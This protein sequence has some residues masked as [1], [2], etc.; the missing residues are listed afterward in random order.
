MPDPS[1][2]IIIHYVY[3]GNKLKEVSCS[4]CKAE[5]WLSSVV[6]VNVVIFVYFILKENLVIFVRGSV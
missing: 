3:L 4:V 1:G 5:G 2:M 6:W